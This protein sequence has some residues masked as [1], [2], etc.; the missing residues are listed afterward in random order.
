[1]ASSML[2]NQGR[3]SDE[4]PS[5]AEPWLGP[6]WPNMA[7]SDEMARSQAMPI[8]CPPATLMPLTRQITGFLQ[9]RME[10]TMWLNSSMYWPY[11]SGRLL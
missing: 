2:R 9:A 5:G 11:S 7:R 8:S 10:S 6:A 4:P 1:M 3:K